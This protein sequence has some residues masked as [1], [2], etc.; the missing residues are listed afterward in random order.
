MKGWLLSSLR[1]AFMFVCGFQ[2]LGNWLSRERGVVLSQH[3]ALLLLT[4]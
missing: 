4:K 1:G 3:S 2:F